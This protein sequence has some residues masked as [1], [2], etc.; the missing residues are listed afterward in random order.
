MPGKTDKYAQIAY[1]DVDVPDGG[2]LTYELL[3]IAQFLIGAPKMGLILH[4]WEVDFSDFIKSALAKGAGAF[5]ECSA[6]LTISNLMSSVSYRYPEVLQVMDRH[7]WYSTAVAHEVGQSIGTIDWSD[8]PGGGILIPA[9]R[10]YL[11]GTC[12][13]VDATV[14]LSSRIWYTTVELTA[15]DYLELVE[16]RTILQPTV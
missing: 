2:T 4:R 1:L 16:Q 10:L 12:T 11:A 7:N 8:L 14:T 13:D 3:Q 6:A 15:Q 9:D 5:Y